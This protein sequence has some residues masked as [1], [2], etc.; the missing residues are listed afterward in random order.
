MQY[1]EVYIDQNTKC[2][3]FSGRWFK[4][5]RAQV[6]LPWPEYNVLN[7]YWSTRRFTLTRIQ[8]V[9]PWLEDCLTWSEHKSVHL[10]Q[11][12]VFLSTRWF[13]LVRIQA[14]LPWPEFNVLNLCW[15]TRWFTLASTVQCFAGI[16][17]SLPQS[18]CKMFDLGQN[19]RRF[20]C[21]NTRWCTGPG[22]K[23]V[24]STIFLCH[25]KRC[26]TIL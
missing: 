7:L 22:C 15:S 1:K 16:Q 21:Q 25:N 20:F 24:Y 11:Y 10:G 12:T 5:V 26:F 8:S 13:T 3:T 18:E 2:C 17:D 14:G 4:L 9:V 23:V 19:T 6:S